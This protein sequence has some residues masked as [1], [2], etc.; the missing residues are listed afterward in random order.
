MLNNFFNHFPGDFVTSEQL[1]I[2]DMLIESIQMYGMDIFYLPRETRDAVD[3]LYG[4][5]VLKTYTKAYPIEMYIE[6]FTGMEGDGDFI[7]KFGLEIRE[8]IRMIVSRRRFKSI[9]PNQIRPNE[10]DLIYVPLLTGFLEIV[11][12]ENHNE[13]AMFYTLGRGRGGN[14]YLH[15]L[16]LRAY[17]F[18]NEIIHTNNAEINNAV[19]NYWPKTQLTVANTISKFVNDE[20]VYQGIDLANS[21]ARAYVFDYIPNTI[22]EVYRTQGIFTSAN[23]VIRGYTSNATANLVSSSDTIP[24]NTVS[25]DIQDNQRL[26]DEVD[27]ILDFSES[28]PFGS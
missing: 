12:V 28:N 14:V 23:G 3:M 20:I 26:S 10:G 13:Q 25:E 6:N 7:S 16:R 17:V 15:A 18:S 9:I 5:D 24:M 8:E 2:E 1:L 4:E 11:S 27:T 19:R 21:S 22:L